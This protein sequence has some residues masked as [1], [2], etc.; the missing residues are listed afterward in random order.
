MKAFRITLNGEFKYLVALEG[1]HILT[2]ILKLAK[3]NPDGERYRPH[4]SSMDLNLGGFI[5]ENEK[6]VHWD[7]LNLNLDDQVLIEIV[8]VDD[9]ERCSAPVLE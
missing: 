1:E 5:V 6:N 3:L 4:G 9:L 7:S 2:C 8:E